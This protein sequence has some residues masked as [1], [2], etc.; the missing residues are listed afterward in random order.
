MKG[1]TGENRKVNGDLVSLGRQL[2]TILG[3]T[4]TVKQ[5]RKLYVYIGSY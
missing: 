2:K 1:L 4:D 3:I 5:R